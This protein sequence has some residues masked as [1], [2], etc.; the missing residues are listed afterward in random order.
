M[1][2]LSGVVNQQS[3]GGPPGS[4]GKDRAPGSD[5]QTA[6]GQGTAT[7]SE[8]QQASLAGM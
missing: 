2:K 7:D 1:E 5:Q 8:S 4:A 6:S 3:P